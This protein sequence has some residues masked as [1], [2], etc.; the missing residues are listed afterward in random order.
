M[1]IKLFF[2]KL[3]VKRGRR[4]LLKRLAEHLQILHSLLIENDHTF[5]GFGF[6][7]LGDLLAIHIDHI[8]ID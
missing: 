8:F 7:C 3:M 1:N 6:C 2:L 5:A 4:Q